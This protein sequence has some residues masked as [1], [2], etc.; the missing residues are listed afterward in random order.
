MSDISDLKSTL[1]TAIRLLASEGILDFNGH[2]SYRLPGTD[3]VL[4]NSRRASR[5]ALRPSDIVTMDLDGRLL[6]GESEPPSEKAI[7]TRIYGAR[8]DVYSVAHL[9]PRI[10]T[11]FSIAGRP[12]APVF[13]A[14]CIFPR[15]GVPVYDDPGLI[16]TPEAGDAPS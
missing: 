11:V 4:I 6:E 2:M 16:H 5:A 10:A 1:A 13:T 12:L 3:R 7:H 15:E 8:P 9:H 14:G